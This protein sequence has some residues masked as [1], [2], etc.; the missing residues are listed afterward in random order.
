MKISVPQELGH[1]ADADLFEQIS[2]GIAFIKESADNLETAARQLDKHSNLQGRDVLCG[3]AEEEVGKALVLL[4]AVRCPSRNERVR[5]LSRFRDHLAKG[6]YVKSVYWSTQNFAQIRE[7]VDDNRQSLHLDGPTDVDWILPNPIPSNRESRMYVDYVRDITEDTGDRFWTNPKGRVIDSFPYAT[8]GSVLLLRAIVA[9]GATSQEGLLVVSDVW[10]NFNI[11]DSTTDFE[12]Y[13]QNKRTLERLD[14]EGLLCDANEATCR[15]FLDMWKA[16]MWSVCMR[17]IQVQIE[18]LRERRRKAIDWR[19][20]QAAKR[21]PAPRISRQTVIALDALYRTYRQDLQNR[22]RSQWEPLRDSNVVLGSA[23][24]GKRVLV[25]RS[26]DE[27][28]RSLSVLSR[29]ERVDLV[30][31]AWFT[32]DTGQSWTE[33]H[34]QAGQTVGRTYGYEIG[35]GNKWLDGYQKWENPPD[36]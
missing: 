35:L 6:I 2:R 8:P 23:F 28:Y 21:E 30:A 5:T 20:K 36:E 13:L 11:T 12:I 15:R 26:Y 34:E 33:L 14:E 31:L 27:L 22:D 3:L 7:Y 25:P 17:P 16:P 32:R 1:L 4:D 9:T 24:F 19:K 10:R 18:D 29:E